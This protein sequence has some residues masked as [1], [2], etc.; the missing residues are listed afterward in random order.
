MGRKAPSGFGDSS[1]VLLGR[2]AQISVPSI[3]FPL[4][5]EELLSHIK[6]GV[7]LEIERIFLPAPLLMFCLQR[8][9]PDRNMGV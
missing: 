8:H 6:P 4:T 1:Q 2:A 9:G 3:L 5:G 7:S